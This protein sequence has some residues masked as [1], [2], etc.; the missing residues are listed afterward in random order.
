MITGEKKL[1]KSDK[2]I[3]KTLR[4]ISIIENVPKWVYVLLILLYALST[5]F[6]SVI[7]RS[8]NVI[9]LFGNHVPVAT[10]TGVMSSFNNL[11]LVFLVVFFYK[12]GYTIIHGY[13]SSHYTDRTSLL[14]KGIQVISC[15]HTVFIKSLP[16][17]YLFL[18][19]YSFRIIS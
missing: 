2:I 5:Y 9:F 13:L 14:I 10:F 6:L 16:D 4:K 15:Q 1:S 19:A 12:L 18:S 8:Q 17:K 7:A 3:D 11:C